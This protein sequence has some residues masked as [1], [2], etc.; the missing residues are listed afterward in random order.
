M[1]N[2]DLTRVDGLVP[3]ATS[4]LGSTAAG[5]QAPPAER[6]PS[7]DVPKVPCTH[8]GAWESRVKDGR[9]VAD[10]YRRKRVC[11]TCGQPFFTI[12]RAA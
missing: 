9:P 10:G 7:P 2:D 11:K 1:R 3:S 6:R 4:R 8:C 5:N 12:E